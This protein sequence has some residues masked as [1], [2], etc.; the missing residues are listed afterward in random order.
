VTKASEAIARKQ[1]PAPTPLTGAQRAELQMIL[2]HNDDYRDP[3]R[4]VGRAETIR[5]LQSLGWSG[6]RYALDKVCVREFNRR[7]FAKR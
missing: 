1:L 3:A 7:N 2:V 5:V 4:R 6:S